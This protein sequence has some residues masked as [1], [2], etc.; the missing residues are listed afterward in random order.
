MVDYPSKAAAPLVLPRG[1]SEVWIARVDSRASRQQR[2]SKCRT[3]VVLQWTKYW[4]GVDL[5]ARPR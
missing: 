4:I 2:M 5:V 3:A 1:R